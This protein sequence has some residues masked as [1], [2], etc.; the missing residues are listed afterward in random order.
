MI[1]ELD[2]LVEQPF[3][4]HFADDAVN[5]RLRAA[6]A[7]CQPV[8]RH[9]AAE[10]AV[11]LF[12]DVFGQGLRCVR[13]DGRFRVMLI[14][15]LE[16]VTD[17]FDGTPCLAGNA[18]ADF[19]RAA[20]CPRQ[21]PGAVDDLVAFGIRHLAEL[22]APLHVAGVPG[23]EPL[24]RRLQKADSFAISEHEPPAHQPAVPP[25]VDRFGRNLKPLADV[26]DRQ[27]LLGRI[28]GLD[29]RAVRQIFNEQPQIVG[30]IFAGDEQIGIHFRTIGRDAQAQI[31]VTVVLRAKSS[32]SSNCSALSICA[33]RTSRGA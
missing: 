4:A 6:I 2:R 14:V 20:A 33:R 29:V 23:D 10:A 17:R 12:L 32:S 25:T 19:G 16:R 24:D 5:A 27:H 9:A 28:L 8:D 7:P 22:P 11:D 18:T 26:F 31:L 30:R 1:H 21:T 13:K 15:V 3:G